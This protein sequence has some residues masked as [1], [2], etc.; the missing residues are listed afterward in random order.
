[1]NLSQKATLISNFLICGLLLYLGIG[2]FFWRDQVLPNITDAE[3][4]IRAQKSQNQIILG[5]YLVLIDP[6]NTEKAL[7]S[8]SKL[9]LKPVLPLINWLLVESNT[10]KT[11]FKI[12][13]I[14]D[15]E[16][17]DDQLVLNS[18]L[19]NPHILDAQHNFYLEPAQYK[20]IK[21]W[22]FAEKSEFVGALNLEKA[23][24]IH[25]GS[26]EQ[27]IAVI[28]NFISKNEFLFAKRFPECQN[29]IQLA[30]PFESLNLD[31][32]KNFHG[33][34]MLLALGACNGEKD[35]SI[36]V[37]SSANLMAID[38]GLG[39]QAQTMAAALW[40]A[41]IDLCEESIVSCPKPITK[42]L[43]SA[44][45][46][47][48]SAANG[49]PDLLQFC[50]DMIEE[51]NRKGTIV[52]AASG[53]NNDEAINYFPGASPG[54]INVG[55]VNKKNQRSKFSNWG[56]ALDILAPGENID[57]VYK[58]LNKT[59]SG[60]SISAALVAGTVSLMKDMKPRLSWKEARHILS[61]S[62]QALSCSDYCHGTKKPDSEYSCQNLCCQNSNTA[63]GAKSLDIYAAL[64][65]TK[66]FAR[67]SGLIEIDQFYIILN[68]NDIGGKNIIV[69][70]KSNKNIYV[71]A[72]IYDE[73][74]EIKPSHFWLSP[75]GLEN[76]EQ[77]VNINFTKEPFKRQT[78]K[79]EFGVLDSGKITDRSE[80]FIEYIHKSSK[81][82]QLPV[83]KY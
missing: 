59:G 11:K 51:I 10:R 72:L 80:L 46:I 31:T 38:R 63:C 23:W 19:Q 82:K 58:R 36:G 6:K 28:D 77:S 45:V 69:K 9:N 67:N 20:Q 33:D 3:I 71:E 21:Q 37:N 62:G 12:V 17:V 54:L 57:F 26:S 24:G 81:L 55:S 2:L 64:Q 16:A 27:N 75:A 74:T 18:L 53:N 79:V 42:P 49:A 48:L 39:G 4:S 40:A 73:R 8:L 5:Q 50:A 56:T 34:L 47:L 1:M 35:L 65:A 83:D 43:K 41:G 44:Q 61:S 30:E 32:G 76:N 78:F 66:D 68:R 29:R 60:T 22:P 25:Q 52:V 7:L 13:D 70:N 14:N 15:N